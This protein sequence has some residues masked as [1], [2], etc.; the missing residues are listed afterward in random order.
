MELLLFGGG[1]RRKERERETRKR[2]KKRKKKN[3][4]FPSTKQIS[5][6]KSNTPSDLELEFEVPFRELGFTGVPHRSAAFVIPTVN[7]LVELTEMPFTVITLSEVVVVNL[8]RVGFGLRNFDMALVFKDPHR[9]VVRIDAIPMTSLDTIREWLSSVDIKF[10]ESKTNLNW[11]QVLKSI[12]EDPEAFREAG[13]WGF[14][15]MEASDDEE[16]EDSE[17]G[18]EEFAPSDSGEEEEEESSDEDDDSE[19]DEDEEDEDDDEEEEDDDDEEAGKSW[20][21]LEAEAAREDRQRAK[22][23]AFDD[24]DD[25]RKG[26]GKKRRSSGGGGGGGGKKHRR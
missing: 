11:K 20:E 14:L 13:G 23:G 25:D 21:E 8:E 9:E 3:S 6:K 4:R 17:D 2:R 18:D 16:G 22:E 24:S 5:K 26:G 19:F 12:T 10:Y 7:C 1:R 15:D